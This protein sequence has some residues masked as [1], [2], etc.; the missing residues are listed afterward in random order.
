VIAGRVGTG[1]TPTAL[2]DQRHYKCKPAGSPRRRR[3]ERAPRSLL[4]G[5]SSG[6]SSTRQR[7]V[8]ARLAPRVAPRCARW[9]LV[10]QFRHR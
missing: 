4:I 2:E 10:C 6:S 1:L 8:K 5:S 7:R 3:P 9:P